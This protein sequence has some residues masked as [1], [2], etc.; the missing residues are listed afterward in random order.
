MRVMVFYRFILFASLATS[1]TFVSCGN[2]SESENTT[3]IAKDSLA[4]SDENTDS[5]VP[6]QVHSLPA[7]M[8]VASAIKKAC[9]T[10]F[11]DLLSPL[12]NETTSDFHKTI[13]LGIYAVDLGY[14]NVYDQKQA[15]INY[16]ITAVK[17]AD[18]LKILGPA[19]PAKIKA[20]KDNVN[21]KDSV[22]FYTL[23]SF[24][25]FH[26]NLLLSERTEEAYLILTGSFI[27]GLYLTTNIQAKN[28]EQKLVHL[29][30]E[31]KL[32]LESTIAILSNSKDKKEISDLIVKLTDL[33]TIY[34]KVD[35]K[36]SEEI[37][38][39][40]TMQ[41]IVITDNQLKQIKDKITEIRN[42]IIH[43]KA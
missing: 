2:S 1:L 4:K 40:K 9:P 28:K 17:L 19:D 21:N 5:L 34:N 25:N 14:S 33:Q 12:K 24:N 41:E 42:S 27:E 23:N 11:E 39:K 20:F 37:Q 13:N 32:F 36:Y 22:T 7:P 6:S 8:Q 43:P 18:E 16:F 15:S 30:G 31:Q 26:E 38:N 3:V 35:I 29:I 10:Y